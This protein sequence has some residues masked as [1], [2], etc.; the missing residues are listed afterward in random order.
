MAEELPPPH[1]P[2]EK[3]PPQHLCQGFTLHGGAV[4]INLAYAVYPLGVVLIATVKVGDL[5]RTIWRRFWTT[6]ESAL[7]AAESLAGD[8]EEYMF[9][10]L[11]LA[12]R[13]VEDLDLDDF[14]HHLD[15]C[16]N[17]GFH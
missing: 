1:F 13:P 2:C 8:A 6:R 12:P 17:N 10:T 9:E 4:D 14:L 11:G 3:D 5:A 15:M 16:L 7:E